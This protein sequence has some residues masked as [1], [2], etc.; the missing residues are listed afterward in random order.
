M[1]DTVLNEYQ[2]KGITL[3]NIII[4]KESRDKNPCNFG[5]ENDQDYQVSLK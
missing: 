1:S 4:S 3:E 5:Q 2:S